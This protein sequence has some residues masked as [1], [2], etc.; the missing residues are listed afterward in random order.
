MKVKVHWIVDGIADV[1]FPSQ[2]EAERWVNE[3]L[4]TL[5]NNNPDFKEKL[6]AKAIQG[7]AYFPGSSE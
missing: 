2:E 6:G 4:Q 7:K 3:T 5:L 1:E